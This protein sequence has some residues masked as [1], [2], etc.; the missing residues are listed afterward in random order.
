MTRGDRSQRDSGAN[1]A[2]GEQPSRT[3]GESK[4]AGTGVRKGVL[5]IV[6]TPIGN[7]RDITLRALDVLGGADAVACEDTRTTGKLLSL[8]GIKSTLISYHEH[9]AAR[10]R[11]AIIERLKSGDSVA[12]VSDAGTPLVND[13]GYKLVEACIAED[14]PVTALPG[15]SSVMCALTLA[16][17]P[18]DRF[19]FA[20]FPPNKPGARRAFLEELSTVPA[21]L[22]FLE[23]AKRLAASLGDMADALD[24][25]PAAVL[26]EMTKMYEE[27][28]RGPLSALAAHYAE[29]GPP[30][31]E[32]V[33]VVGPPADG[34]NAL[35]GEALDDLLRDAL[36]AGSLRD[37][38][39]TV[40]AETGLAK[41]AVYERAVVLKNGRE[42][43]AGG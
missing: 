8:H 39:R 34:A 15:A 16:G 13:P 30:K 29:S 36:A 18:T 20:G 11:P 6:A 42:N 25:R 5:H 38:V 32:I 10:A 23:S 12:L 3:V 1:G 2:G 35:S 37:A 28:R 21:T 14:I 41:N 9:N 43:D 31:G 40:V 4:P 22:V 27:A 19:L 24:D 33:I 17:L 7:A 26:R